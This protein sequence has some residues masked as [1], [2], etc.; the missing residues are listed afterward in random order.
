[1]ANKRIFFACQQI[2]MK[3]DG[4]ANYRVLH[5]VQNASMST[6]FNLEQVFALGQLAIYENKEQ[7][8]EVEVTIS[9]VLDG[10][11]LL[12][13]EATINASSPTLVGRSNEK[14]LV[15]FGIFSDTASGASGKPLSEVEVSGAFPTSLSYTFPLE[16][17]FT[18]E[19]SLQASDKV[20]AN[21]SRML[22][23]APWVGATDLTYNGQFSTDDAPIGSGGVNNR[24][25]LIFAYSSDSSLDINGQVAD[26]DATILPK[27]IY[28]ITSSGTNEQGADGFGAHVKSLSVSVDISRTPEYEMGRLGPYTRTVEFPVEVTC[29][30]TVGAT[31]GDMVSATEQG[32]LSAAASQ[33]AVNGSLGNNTIRIATCEGTRLYLGKKN[34][35]SATNYSGGDAGGGNVEVSYTYSNFN[36]LTVLHS[37]DPNTNG[38]TWWTNRANYL[39]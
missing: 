20:W 2:A 13:H 12:W 25:N 8:P 1:M 10:Y 26:P 37:G 6:S 34:K 38:A 31:S 21:D 29:E 39:T 33:C 36:E 24:K 19:I 11:P 28:G 35:L 18:E 3:G 23:A 9:K 30:I 14:C 7:L 15:A 16:G 22:Q 32:I 27:E 4:A 5:G 17:S